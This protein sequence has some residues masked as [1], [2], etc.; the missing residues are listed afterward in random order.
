MGYLFDR[1]G[2]VR[3][4]FVKERRRKD[5]VDG[6]K[7]RF[8]FMGCLNLLFSPFIVIYLLIYSFFRYFE[9]CPLSHL[10]HVPLLKHRPLPYLNPN[11]GSV[12]PRNLP[13]PTSITDE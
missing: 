2:Q 9:V 5:L 8:V 3:K 10:S 13:P 7:R 12:S 4:E 11:H 1:R 6:L